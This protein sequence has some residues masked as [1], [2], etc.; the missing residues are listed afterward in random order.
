MYPKCTH[1]QKNRCIHILKFNEIR[2]N[3]GLIKSKKAYKM[4][5]VL[6]NNTKGVLTINGLLFVAITVYTIHK[7]SGGFL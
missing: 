2:E 6:T 5:C 3:I 7:K 4:A 1:K